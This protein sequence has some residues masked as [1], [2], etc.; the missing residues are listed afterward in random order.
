MC[1]CVS[2][3]C[4]GERVKTPHANNIIATGEDSIVDGRNDATHTERRGVR[5]RRNRDDYNLQFH[6]PNKGILPKYGVMLSSGTPLFQR[7]SLCLLS[8]DEIKRM[9][10]GGEFLFSIDGLVSLIPRDTFFL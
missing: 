1:T 3:S 6:H 4:W 7:L 5:S 2:L 8:H 9:R 10:E